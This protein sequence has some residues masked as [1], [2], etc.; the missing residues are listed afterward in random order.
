MPTSFKL[1]IEPYLSSLNE[2]ARPITKSVP[3]PK[4]TSLAISPFLAIAGIA[5]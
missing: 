4:T 3:E 1:P 2:A 5:S